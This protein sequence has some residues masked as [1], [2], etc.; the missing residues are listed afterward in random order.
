MISGLPGCATTQEQPLGIV[1]SNETRILFIATLACFLVLF[2]FQIV[3]YNALVDEIR[4]GDGHVNSF[5]DS[6]HSQMRAR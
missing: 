2:V 5:V 1:M 3:G 4:V 6:Q